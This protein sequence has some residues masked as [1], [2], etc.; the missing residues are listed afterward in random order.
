MASPCWYKLYAN[1]ELIGESTDPLT[2]QSYTTRVTPD[3]EDVTFA[4]KG[5]CKGEYTGYAPVSMQLAA[6]L[7]DI[8]FCEGYTTDCTWKCEDECADE[9]WYE[10]EYDDSL[11]VNATLV[12]G[13]NGV[14]PWGPIDGISESADWIWSKD[15]YYYD[16]ADGAYP[17]ERI[18]LPQTGKELSAKQAAGKDLSSKQ[19]LPKLFAYAYCRKT[20]KQCSYCEAKGYNRVY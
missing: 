18:E 1:G 7:G 6:F 14:R 3:V 13:A 8:E 16:E 15:D 20:V 12:N 17:A 11:W 10:P 4:V 2:V 5:Y 19:A 9:D